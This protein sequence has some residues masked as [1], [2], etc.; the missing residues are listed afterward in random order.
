MNEKK[1]IIQ[2]I[3]QISGQWSPYQVF[4]DWVECVALTI[5]NNCYAFCKEKDELYQKREQRYCSIIKKYSAE[6]QSFIVEMTGLLTMAM[7]IEFSDIL[8]EIYMESGCG[9]KNTGQFFTPFNVSKMCADMTLLQDFEKDEIIPVHEPSCGAGGMIIAMASVL[10][11]KGINYQKKMRVV[12]QD[13][14]WKAVYMTYVQLSLYG[15]DAVV[16]QGDTLLDPY[17]IDYP[18]ERT[19]RTPRNMGVIL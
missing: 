2:R 4:T 16:V 18:I 11:D 14:D 1:E 8:G 6:E 12:A 15:I 19:F 3:Q 17:H 10:K 13:L 5:Q 7:E 9:N